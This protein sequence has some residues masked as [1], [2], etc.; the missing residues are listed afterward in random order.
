MFC[1]VGASVSRKG[2]PE[3]IQ[4]PF[5]QIMTLLVTAG[6]DFYPNSAAGKPINTET[7]VRHR[8]ERRF[9]DEVGELLQEMAR[10]KSLRGL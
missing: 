10:Q 3:P 7:T 5:I 1:Y 2:H 4:R 8:P 6:A 9:P